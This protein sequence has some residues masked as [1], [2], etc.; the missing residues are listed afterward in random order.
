MTAQGR[1]GKLKKGDS[2][3]YVVKEII[4]DNGKVI[5]ETV[6]NFANENEMENGIAERKIIFNEKRFAAVLEGDG[7]SYLNL[8]QEFKIQ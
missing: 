3:K 4:K 6:L 5:S 7:I 2:M 1:G 8:V